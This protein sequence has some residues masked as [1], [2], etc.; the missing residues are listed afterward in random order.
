MAELTVDGLRLAA[1]R[2]EVPLSVAVA[3]EGLAGGGDAEPIGSLQNLAANLTH[4]FGAY[5]VLTH[6]YGI[7]R[8]AL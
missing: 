6:L 5:A 3:I 8:A 2:L 4:T 1:G 7:T